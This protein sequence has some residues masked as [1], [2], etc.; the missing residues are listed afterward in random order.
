MKKLG[1]GFMRL[2]LLDGNDPTSFDKSQ[3]CEMVDKFL[4]LGFN[5]FDTAYMYHNGTS[6]NIIKEVLVDRYDRSDFLLATKMPTMMLKEKDDLERI[7]SEQLEKTGA[8]YFDYYLMH[9]L[10]KENYE[11]TERLGGFEFALEKKSQGLIK[12]LGFSFHDT[13]E[14]LDKILTEHPETEFVQLQINYLDWDSEDVQSERCYNIAVKHGKEVIVMEPIKGGSLANVPKRAEKLFKETEPQMS[15]A[16][17]AIRFAASLPNVIMVLSGMSNL[18]QLCDNTSY[19]NNFVPLNNNEINICMN[20]ADIIKSTIAVNC[21]KCR[22]CIE[23]CPMNI[24]ICEYFA[25]LNA[26]NSGEKELCELKTEYSG[27]AEKY[28]KASDCIG[29]GQCEQHCPQHIKIISTLENT[30]SVF[31]D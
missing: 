19:M 28:G 30:A 20:A 22:Y 5:Y 21:T 15:V 1:F 4:E 29:C 2:P 27:F 13:P 24:A 25:L 10:T 18:G 12:K 14:L 8:E 6:E 17:W 11:I 16:S 26:L 23:G 31:E 9:C 3:I 7:F